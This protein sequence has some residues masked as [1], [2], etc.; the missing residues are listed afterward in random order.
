MF[1]I[2]DIVLDKRDVKSNKARHIVDKAYFVFTGPCEIIR[3][4]K[5]RS[6]DSSH[7]RS[8]KMEKN[9][10]MHI[11]PVPQEMIAFAPLDGIDTK[12]GQIYKNINYEAYKAAG[13]D[14]LF[15]HNP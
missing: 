12:Y 1:E 8:S 3:K 11:C 2:V 14:G 10:S 7:T 13:I 4:L 6:Y 9:H 5:G 15:P